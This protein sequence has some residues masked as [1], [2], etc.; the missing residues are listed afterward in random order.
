LDY[1]VIA[2]RKAKSPSGGVF[3]ALVFDAEMPA[4]NKLQQG[5]RA[6]QRLPVEYGDI[7]PP[8]L[9]RRH[10]TATLHPEM[11]TRPLHSPQTCQTGILR[12]TGK[13]QVPHIQISLHLVSRLMIVISEI[14][15]ANECSTRSD[16]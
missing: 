6:I 5:G 11:R 9:L 15:T 1:N 12:V 7:S 4:R 13:D 16:I 10:N 2:I 14:L 3:E 8:L